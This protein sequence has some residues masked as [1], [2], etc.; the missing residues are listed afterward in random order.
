MVFERLPETGFKKGDQA[1]PESACVLRGLVRLT[2][3]ICPDKATRQATAIDIEACFDVY[4]L[5]QSKKKTWCG[6][7][8]EW[9]VRSQWIR[10]IVKL[11]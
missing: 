10:Q 1:K 5:N 2:K 7:L 3:D 11:G 9:M 8:T 4:D 6:L